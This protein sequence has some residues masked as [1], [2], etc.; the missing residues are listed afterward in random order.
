MKNLR[1]FKKMCHVLSTK[2]NPI[3]KALT[4]L[5]LSMRREEDNSTKLLKVQQRGCCAQM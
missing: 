2:K 4:H 1:Y 3:Y 5:W